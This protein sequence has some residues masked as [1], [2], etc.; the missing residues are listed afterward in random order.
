VG[1]Q[2][3]GVSL[4]LHQGASNSLRVHCLLLRAVQGQERVYL[5]LDTLKTV[6]T[7]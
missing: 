6:W 7:S 3:G 1:R 4:C 5:L 2:P